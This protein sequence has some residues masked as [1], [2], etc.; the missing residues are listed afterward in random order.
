[1]LVLSRGRNDKIVFPNLGITVEIL[2]IA[3][4]KV[5]VGVDAPPNV[6]VL[7]HELAGNA[8]LAQSSELLNPAR[9]LSHDI[10]NRLHAANLALHLS[11]K[12]LQ[13]GRNAEAEQTLQKAL[14]EFAAVEERLTRSETPP[15]V[16]QPSRPRGHALIVE[17]NLNESE[18]LASYL[19]LSGFQVDTA[20][21]GCDAL[22]LLETELRPD[23]ILLDMRM[24]RCDG[25]ATITAIRANPD[26]RRLKVYAISGTSPDSLGV[27]RGPQGVDRWFPKPLNPEV[28]VRELSRELASMSA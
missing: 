1:M 15:P 27:Q 10:R 16:A 23:A 13:A 2:N 21:D 24:P 8:P 12:L 20:R 28:L 5:R 4:S 11:Q 22:S 7:R 9:K 17:D 6:T 19:R 25:P 26:F 18:L 14:D 3:G